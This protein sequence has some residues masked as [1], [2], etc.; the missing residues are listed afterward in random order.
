MVG[1]PAAGALS[2]DFQRFAQNVNFAV[3]VKDEG[4]F[5]IY[6][7]PAAEVL[8][9]YDPGQ[10]L[11]CHMTDICPADPRIIEMAFARL[12]R[13]GA[14]SGRFPLRRK[15][16]E[17]IEVA[18]HAVTHVAPDGS[19]FYLDVCYTLESDAQLAW[20]VDRRGRDEF[21]ALDLCLLQLMVEGLSDDELALLHGLP[22]ETIAERVGVAIRDMGAA[23]RTEACVRAIKRAL[24]L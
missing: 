20:L 5:Y 9:G 18:S 12:Q 23:S 22:E 1:E 6:A 19:L 8:M 2:L 17:V 10:L 14:W 21:G 7:N 15:D 16:G 11:G 24:V 13:E 3:F 4:G